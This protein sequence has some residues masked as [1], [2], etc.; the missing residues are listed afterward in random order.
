MLSPLLSTVRLHPLLVT[1]NRDYEKCGA[2]WKGLAEVHDVVAECSRYSLDIYDSSSR[3]E[4]GGVF[5]LWSEVSTPGTRSVYHETAVEATPDNTPFTTPSKPQTRDQF[6]S[7]QQQ[8]VRNIFQTPEPS[9]PSKTQASPFKESSPFKFPDLE[10]RDS[11]FGDNSALLQH[12]FLTKRDS[13]GLGRIRSLND[14]STVKTDAE[15]DPGAVSVPSPVKFTSTPPQLR[16]TTDDTGDDTGGECDD[17]VRII[18]DSVVITGGSRT[19]SV[20]SETSDHDQGAETDQETVTKLVDKVMKRVRRITL[21][22][23]EDNQDDLIDSGA[24]TSLK[25]SSS[26]PDIDLS[27]QCQEPGSSGSK[28]NKSN[29]NNKLRFSSGTQTETSFNILPHQTLFPLALPLSAPV[30]GKPLPPQQKLLESY[31]ESAVS[32]VERSGDLRCEVDMLRSQLLFET[33]RRETLGVRNRRL[34][35]FTKNVRELEEQNLALVD[36]L[37]LAR[38]EISTLQSQVAGVRSGKHQ[39]ETERAESCRLQDKLIQNLQLKLEQLK[40]SNRELKENYEFKESELLREVTSCDK[41]R[42]ELFQSQAKLKVLEKKEES[43][44]RC[45]SE[46]EKLQVRNLLQGELG[47]YF[48]DVS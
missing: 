10:R 23:P 9:S 6:R 32:R 18:T 36:K 11:L 20:I 19:V 31:I 7:P 33:G 26:C 46:I 45:Q 44:K 25:R 48:S 24:V 28:S 41:A 21:C 43:W 35:G 37:H 39:A 8:H 38:Q 2:R 30:H 16:F 4:A 3:E 5:S 42:S 15:H 14:S 12:P 17:E 13:L 1:H 29:K 40:T 47:K 22:D 27:I 34:L